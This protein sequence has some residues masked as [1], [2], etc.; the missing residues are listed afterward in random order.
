MMKSLL[1]TAAVLVALTVPASASDRIP[2]KFRG[3]WCQNYDE[4]VGAST[5]IYKRTLDIG[6]CKSL[7][8]FAD[9]LDDTRNICMALRVKHL[10]N[11]KYLVRTRCTKLGELPPYYINF[12]MSIDRGFLLVN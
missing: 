12:K 5:V 11:G 7:E 2:E 6:T 3:D 9:R 1:T 10:G 4:D 8:I